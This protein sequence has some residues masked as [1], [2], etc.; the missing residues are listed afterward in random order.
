MTKKG[1]KMLNPAKYACMNQWVETAFIEKSK[2]TNC[3]ISEIYDFIKSKFLH[4]TMTIVSQAEKPK[5]N[6]ISFKILLGFEKRLKPKLVKKYFNEFFIQYKICIELSIYSVNNKV[7]AISSFSENNF[8]LKYFPDEISKFFS[9]KYKIYKWSENKNSLS[10]LKD[11]DSFVKKFR[12]GE[13]YCK[14]YLNETI[15]HRVK[16]NGYGALGTSSSSTSVS[17]QLFKVIYLMP[18]S[19]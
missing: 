7:V 17:F 18:I 12:Y 8:S 6:Q 13:N 15:K 9:E 11:D 2:L 19:F 3:G 1:Y 10:D 16:D 5:T 14:S 4:L